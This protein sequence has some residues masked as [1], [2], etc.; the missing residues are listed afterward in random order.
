LTKPQQSRRS[1]RI[2]TLPLNLVCA[3]H[4]SPTTAS[5]TGRRAWR[6]RRILFVQATEPANYP[7]LIH[8]S[9]LMAE[10]GWEVTFLSAPISGN[11]LELAR[12]PR[13]AVQAI[14]MRPSHVWGKAAYVR[15]SAAAARLAL[16]LRPDVVYASD[17]LGAGPGLLAARL[18]RARL[19]YHEYDS[20]TAGSL[21]P[22]LA[23]ARAAAARR[24]ELVI[25]PNEARARIARAEL[26]FS[27]NRLRIVWNMPRR[28]ELPPV[29]SQPEPPLVIYYHGSINPDR[30]PAAV[31]EAVRQLCGRACLRI[32]GYEA[33]GAAGYVQRLIELGGSGN[34]TRLVDYVGQVPGRAD[35]VATAAQAHVGLAFVSCN[36]NDMNM[37]HMTGASNKPFDYM[38]AGLALLVSD[39][40]DWRNMFVAPGFARACDPSDPASIAAAFAWFID[41]PAERRAM[42]AS[43]RAR[44]EAAWNYDSAFAPVMSF[45]SNA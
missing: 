27:A 44:I 26:G 4:S 28:A 31:V 14:P 2:R 34:S 22:S 8:A 5:E 45:L 1:T 40:P 42:G 37:R 36:G 29:E 21:H 3:G 6:N 11:R 19:V 18:A 16:R 25:F 39:L 7:P 12:H 15:Y 32:A 24:A 43:G 35:L 13:V 17:P 41:H 23:R 9:M 30:L 33:P 10:A 20:P 38:A